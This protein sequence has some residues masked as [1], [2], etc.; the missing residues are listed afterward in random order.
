MTNTDKVIQVIGIEN[1]RYSFDMN[2]TNDTLIVRMVRGDYLLTINATENYYTTIR[3][4]Y[5]DKNKS[6][7][8]SNHHGSADKA[9]KRYIKN[10]YSLIVDGKIVR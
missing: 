6:I 7:V 8:R 2:G 9:I 1:A 10:G 5:S 4:H 3:Q